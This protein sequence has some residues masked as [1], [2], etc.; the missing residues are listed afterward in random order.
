MFSTVM[1]AHRTMRISTSTFRQCR[2]RAPFFSNPAVSTGQNTCFVRTFSVDEE[3]ID[4]RSDS[5]L[6]LHDAAEMGDVVKIKKL[7]Q[8]G[9][10]VNAG[11]P[12]RSNATALHIASRSGHLVV[13]EELVKN[14]AKLD[15]LGPWN[16]TPL[17][18]AIIFGRA[19]VVSFLLK[20]GVDTSIEDS[21]GRDAL[22]HATNERQFDIKELLEEHIGAGVEKESKISVRRRIRRRTKHL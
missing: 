15:C 20:T 8:E 14:G 6:A 2:R 3:V 7:L 9:F 16:M 17:M 22:T 18:Y 4:T 12:A 19:D 5:T 11:D 13:V 1:F 10:G 21:R